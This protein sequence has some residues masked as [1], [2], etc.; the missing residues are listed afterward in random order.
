MDFTLHRGAGGGA[1]PGRADLRGPGHR[2]AGE[3]GRGRRRAR[4]PGAV[5]R[6]GRGRPARHR[7]A[8]GRRR[9]RLRARRAVPAARAAGP[10]GWRPCRC[11]PTLCS[12]RLP[13]AEFGTAEQRARWL[14]GVVAGDVVLSAALER[15]APEPR[16]VDGAGWRL[17][18]SRS[19]RALPPHLADAG[20]RARTHRRGVRAFLVDPGGRGRR[21]SS[22]GDHQPRDPVATSS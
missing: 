9:E 22:G 8:R 21:A 6:A 3:G 19:E 12:A 15:S 17:D 7:R 5:G 14:P 10:H 16:A 11:W 18:G 4:R 20:A 1:R 13:I 2:R